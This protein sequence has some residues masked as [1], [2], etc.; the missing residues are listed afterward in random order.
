MRIFSIASGS[1]GNCIYVGNDMTHVLVDVGISGKRVL[2]G[3]AN[4]SLTLEDIDAILITHEHIDHI[5]GLGVLL[6][7]RS[8]PVY[9]TKGTIDAILNS[10]SIGTVDTSVFQEIIPDQKFWINTLHA[11]A[12]STW[13]DA[14][15][16]VCYSFFDE[17]GKIS[18]ATDLGDFDDYLIH[19]L[20]R[21]DV[22]L[23]ESNHDVRMVQANQRYTYALKQRILGKRGHLS[24]ER[25]GEMMVELLKD[26]QMKAI[27]LGHL[28]RDNN[29][30]ECALI[31]MENYMAEAGME[32]DDIIIKVAKRDQC[33]VDI[34]I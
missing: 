24:N 9:T 8:I 31:N 5:K 6:R 11:D 28:S 29:I 17:S 27:I 15:D 34:T 12:S 3:L 16:P 21:S 20:K 30:P 25:S 1:S 26:H 14:A 23:V 18:I 32:R 33:S 4:L 7:K 10:T 13:H 2:E 22:M 19:K